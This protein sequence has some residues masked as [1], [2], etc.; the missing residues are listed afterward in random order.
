MDD[1]QSS[2]TDYLVVN[3]FDGREEKV[4]LP[5]SEALIKVGRETDNDI[6]LSDPRASRY[7]AQV[8]RGEAGLEIM[9]VGSANGTFVGAQRIEA[10]TWQPLPIGSVAYMGDTS[11]TFQPSPASAQTVAVAPITSPPPPPPSDSSDTKP[12]FVPWAVIAGAL[13]V[14]LIIIAGAILL[15]GRQASTESTTADIDTPS[16]LEAQ[17]PGAPPSTDAPLDEAELIPYPV[18]IVEEVRAEPIIL[19]A[20]PDPTKAFIIVRVRVEN[21]GTGD[22]V[23]SPSQFELVDASGTVLTEEGVKYSEDGLRKLGLADRFKDLRLGAGG[24]VP[25]S[26]LF[27]GEA[28]PYEF[29]LRYQAPGLDPITLDLGELDAEQAV[30]VA[31]GTPVAEETP[32]AVAQAS[33]TSAAEPTPSPTRPPELPA[34]R[35]VPIS[36]L[37]GTI[38]YPVFNGTTYDLYLGNADGSGTSFYLPSASQPQFSSDGGRIAYHSWLPEKRALITRDVPG[39]NEHIVAGNLEDQLP[40]WS[41]DGTTIIFLSRRRGDRASELLG[42]S[43]VGG[44][45]QVIG[46]GEYPT[47]AL[48]GQLAFKGWGEP[49]DLGIRFS[50]PDLSDPVELTNNDTDTAPAVSPDGKQIAFM[51]RRDGNWNIYIV[52]SD[53]SGLSQLTDD[54]AEDGLPTWSPD[55]KVIAFVSNRGGPWAVW[56]VPPAGGGERQLFTMEG[57]PDGFVAGEDLDKSRGWAEERISWTE[58]DY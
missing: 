40:T 35:T 22:L 9:D 42:V 28:I 5:A 51:S 26:L 21:Q 14:L 25:E 41:P 11:F 33:A 29:F 31:L 34:P 47:W 2:S 54:P 27:A 23:V 7:H 30:A 13:V 6:V 45:P 56:A 32:L 53:G 55:G 15:A 36:S 1:T 18:V 37:A 52:N 8:R 50:P 46:H 38:A 16:G 10:S 20:L 4:S 48:G 12:T 24:S 19:G 43:S 39:G 58:V 49:Q 57:S 17:T 3:H 44:D